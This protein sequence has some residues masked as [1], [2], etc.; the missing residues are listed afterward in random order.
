MLKV[1]SRPVAIPSGLKRQSEV[2]VVLGLRGIQIRGAL[3]RRHRA[4]SVFECGKC[5]P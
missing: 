5:A 1:L 3:E 2:V 4:G